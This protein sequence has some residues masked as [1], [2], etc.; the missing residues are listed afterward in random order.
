MSDNI[1][2]VVDSCRKLLSKAG[3]PRPLFEARILLLHV[4][5]IPVQK[6]IGWP[7][8][9]LSTKHII[10]LNKLLLRRCN[11]EP[12]AYL[13]GKKSFL[14]IEVTVTKDTLIPRPDSEVTAI[15]LA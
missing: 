5:G 2:N 7:E 8:K 12:Y 11:H 15:S 13:V 3:I 10:K 9:L 6:Q 1:Q 4:S 14:D